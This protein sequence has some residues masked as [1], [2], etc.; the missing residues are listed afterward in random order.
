LLLIAVAFIAASHVSDTREGLL[1]EVVTLLAGLAGVGLLLY[2]LVPR[3]PSAG[4]PPHGQA[5]TSK[6]RRTANDL[7][8]GAGGIAISLILLGGLAYSGGWGWAAMG[9]VLLIPMIAGSGYLLIE[10]SR[11]AERDWTLDLRRLFGRR[12][13]D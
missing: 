12:S 3:R 4:G 6:P 11:A 9:G 8:L 7:L 13:G 10:F 2:G 5:A 1:A